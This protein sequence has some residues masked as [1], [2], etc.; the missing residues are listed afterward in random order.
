M[1]IL[2][3][4]WLFIGFQILLELGLRQ[5]HLSYSEIIEH[6]FFLRN[7]N[8]LEITFFPE[9][10][11]LAIEEWFYLPFHALLWLGLRV[12]SR[13]NIAFLSAVAFFFFFQPSHG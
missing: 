12:V 11:S 10:W 5:R 6:A 9:S 3:L 1:F 4:F 13:F 7:F 8:A 2:P